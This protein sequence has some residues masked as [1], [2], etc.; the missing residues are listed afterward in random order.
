MKRIVF[1][2]STFEDLVGWA[3]YDN[4][5]YAKIVTLFNISTELFHRLRQAG[6][7]AA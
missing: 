3:T 4:K 7:I 1:E 2:Y 6:T 5:V